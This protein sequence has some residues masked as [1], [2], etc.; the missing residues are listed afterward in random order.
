MQFPLSASTSWKMALLS[1]MFKL[2]SV[3]ESNKIFKRYIPNPASCEFPDI[4][5]YY[6]GFLFPFGGGVAVCS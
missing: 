2:V 5:R 4:T 6:L 1:L 3:Q